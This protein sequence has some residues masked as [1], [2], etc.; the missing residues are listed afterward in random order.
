MSKI[1]QRKKKKTWKL[2]TETKSKKVIMKKRQMRKL[3]TMRKRKLTTMRKR[4]LTT[5]RKRKLT[6]MMKNGQMK[7]VMM[8]KKMKK[9]TTMRKR[10]LTTM[11]MKK[12]MSSG[13]GKGSGTGTGMAGITGITGGVIERMHN[14]IGRRKDRKQEVAFDLRLQSRK[15][16]TAIFC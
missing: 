5:M 15:L 1:L 7:K 4:K 13:T 14:Q 9:L 6:T 12:K 11:M 2:R 16:E 8:K 10:K 3:T